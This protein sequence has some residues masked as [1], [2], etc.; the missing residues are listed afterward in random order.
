MSRV[1][2]TLP[3]VLALMLALL[4]AGARQSEASAVRPL[5]V[6]ATVALSAGGGATM[7]QRGTFA[8]APLGRGRVSLRTT[9]GRGRGAT[10]RFEL[11]TPRGSVRGTGDVALIFRGS[12]VVYRGTARIT[13]G[14]GAF[15]AVRGSGRRVDGRGAL[16]GERFA[17]RLTGRVRT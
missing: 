11:A 16:A 13:A 2:A 6:R 15:A 14:T 3:V 17:V 10:F 5:D 8:G 12:T 1:A 7:L 9:I 4:G